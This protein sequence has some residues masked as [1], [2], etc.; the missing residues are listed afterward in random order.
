MVFVKHKNDRNVQY[1]LHLHKP[2]GII[3][4]KLDSND[5]IWNTHLYIPTMPRTG[6]RKEKPLLKC[7][8]CPYTTVRKP[9][10][11][12]HRRIHTGERPYV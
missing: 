9:F 3:L 2:L 6:Y 5:L 4:M 10:M 8:D 11:V 7:E 1:W 12:D